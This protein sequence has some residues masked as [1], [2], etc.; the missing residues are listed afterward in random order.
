MILS[1]PKYINKYP[2][3]GGNLLNKIKLSSDKVEY[4]TRKLMIES[5]YN[6]PFNNNLMILTKQIYIK[7]IKNGGNLSFNEFSKRTKFLLNIWLQNKNSEEINRNYL[8]DFFDENYYF[9]INLK[10][11]KLDNTMYGKKKKLQNMLWNNED[12]HVKKQNAINSNEFE[13]MYLHNNKFNYSKK[14]QYN[15]IGRFLDANDAITNLNAHNYKSKE[16]IR[17]IFKG[18]DNKYISQEFYDII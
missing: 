6:R 5:N 8:L 7:Y 4:S 1:Y 14:F 12:L 9:L 15:N 11:N 13:F 3:V 10:N 2:S 16:N 18:N 17:R